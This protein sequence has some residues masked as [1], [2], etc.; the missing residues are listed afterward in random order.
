MNVTHLSNPVVRAAVQAMNDADRKAWSALF[1]AGAV[2]T[3]A[4]HRRSLAQWSEHELFGPGKGHL[5]SIERQEDDG[6]TVHGRFHSNQWGELETILRFQV[7][8]GKI[9]RL[10]VRTSKSSAAG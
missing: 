4:G 9:R 8:G 5:A 1:E 2:L 10:D 7:D 3:E 6:L